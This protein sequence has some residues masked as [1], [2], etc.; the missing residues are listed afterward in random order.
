M[1]LIG[2]LV[3]ST[4]GFAAG[5]YFRDVPANAWY[6]W[7]VEDLSSKGIIGG[8]P[9]GTFRPSEKVSRAEVAVMLAQTLEYATTGKIKATTPVQTVSNSL[10]FD[11]CGAL[12]KYQNN[13]WFSSLNTLYAQGSYPED[14]VGAPNGE[15]CLS[16]D[17]STFIFIPGDAAQ[18]HRCG[19]IFQFNIKENILRPAEQAADMTHFCAAEFG[20]RINN[21]ILYYG[22]YF[23]GESCSADKGCMNTTGKYYFDSNTV[24]YR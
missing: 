3:G 8:Y 6:A 13:S 19:K 4:V 20:K 12:S 21:Y 22:E 18:A 9:D 7:A 2:L 5:K 10:K 16:T 11:S 1:I 17:E 15:G 24:S 14:T 23:R